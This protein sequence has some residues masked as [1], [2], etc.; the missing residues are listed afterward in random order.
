LYDEWA[1]GANNRIALPRE[2]EK[3]ADYLVDL[4]LI[5]RF[6]KRPYRPTYRIRT[7][8]RRC[9]EDLQP[10]KAAQSRALWIAGNSNECLVAML[11]SL[12]YAADIHKG[13]AFSIKQAEGKEPHLLSPQEVADLITCSLKHPL[14]LAKYKRKGAGMLMSWY[15]FPQEDYGA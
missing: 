2:F 12:G 14:A 8:G 3:S 4:G 10:K 9:Y 15:S 6:P 5:V 13:C 7:A 1:K 11:H